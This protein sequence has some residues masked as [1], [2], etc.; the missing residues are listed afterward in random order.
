TSSIRDGIVAA[1]GPAWHDFRASVSVGSDWPAFRT[2]RT[3]YPNDDLMELFQVASGLVF[4]L[5]YEGYHAL[6][7][8]GG[9]LKLSPQV[10]EDL[11]YY[12]RLRR[13]FEMKIEPLPLP[14]EHDKMEHRLAKLRVRFH[15]PHFELLYR[16]WLQAEGTLQRPDVEGCLSF[17]ACP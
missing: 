5:S 14:R 12:F 8:S 1:Y 17:R 3:A 4:H 13:Q 9:D 10:G 6:I 11:L 7:L 15:S 16:Q 2:E